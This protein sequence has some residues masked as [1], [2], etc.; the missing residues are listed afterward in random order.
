[1]NKAFLILLLTFSTAVVFGQKN[2]STDTAKSKP[3]VLGLIDEIQ[4]KELAEKR[5]LNIYLPEGYKQNDTTKYP[6]IYLLDGSADEDFI[7]IV[8]LVQFNSFEWVNQVPKSIVVG[9]ATV[10]RKR[11]FT[12]HTSIEG[13]KKRYPTTGHSDKFISFIEKELQPYIQAKYKTNANKTLIGQSL[14]GLLATEILIKRP[15]I[16]NKYIIISPSLWWD[17]GSLL[18]QDSEIKENTFKQQT[19]VYIAVGKEGLTPTEIPRVM[20]VDANLLTE[21]IKGFKNKS[22]KVYFDFL[23]QENHATIMH[24]AVSNSFKFLYPVVK[25]D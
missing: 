23:P 24:Q 12:F 22:V 21:K 13:D 17:N 15:A 16:F 19:D 20:E 4:S 6:V 11:D 10:D 7:H 8:G 18:N 5:I 1:M 2:K 9:I 14:G 3:F 25:K